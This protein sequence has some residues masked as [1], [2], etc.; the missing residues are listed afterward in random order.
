MGRSNKL[1]VTNFGFYFSVTGALR[2]SLL[3]DFGASLMARDSLWLFG[4]DYLEHSS[5]EGSHRFDFQKLFIKIE[6]I[7]RCWCNRAVAT[8]NSCIE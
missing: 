4:I 3:F 6:T 2:E 1:N 8:K 5:V 7:F